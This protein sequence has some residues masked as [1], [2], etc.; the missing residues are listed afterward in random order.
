MSIGTDDIEAALGRSTPPTSTELAQWAMWI[1]DAL[2]L[3]EARLG[4]PDELN[5]AR[6]AYVVREAV[7]AHIRRPDDA[8]HVDV[9]VDDGRVSKTYRTSAGRITIRDEWWNLLSPQGEG[10]TAFSIRPSSSYVEH[11]PWCASMFGAVYCSCGADIAGY[12]IFE[13][14]DW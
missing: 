6:L 11:L 3:I 4:D 2:L 7:I 14:A 5:Q 10:G 8:T 9:A 12:P 1:D 13:G